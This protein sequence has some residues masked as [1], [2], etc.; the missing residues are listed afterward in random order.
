M[1]IKI[2]IVG[3]GNLGKGVLCG[4]KQTRDLELVALFTRRNPDELNIQQVNVQHISK[5]SEYKG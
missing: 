5:I 2:G 4:L 3:Y 1:A